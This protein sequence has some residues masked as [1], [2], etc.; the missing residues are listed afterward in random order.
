MR[1]E[2]GADDGERRLAP[3]AR[4]D[5]EEPEFPILAQLVSRLRLDRRR[6]AG[7]HAPRL[8]ARAIVQVRLLARS[9]WRRTV[10]RMPPPARAIA[11]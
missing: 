8:G 5:R 6:A 9:A 2:R 10:E 11:P 3:Y 4:A 7:Q 1:R